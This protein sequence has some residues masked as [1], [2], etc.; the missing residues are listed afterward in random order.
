LLLFTKKYLRNKKGII[1][2]DLFTLLFFW[3]WLVTLISILRL[4]WRIEKFCNTWNILS[5]RKRSFKWK[6]II[7]AFIFYCFT[8][9][10][11]ILVLKVKHSICSTERLF[12]WWIFFWSFVDDFSSFFCFFLQYL[13]SIYCVIVFL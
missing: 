4:Y 1:L 5:R 2:I 9:V 11:V 3:T 10:F 6:S 13:S 7:S 8:K 12:L